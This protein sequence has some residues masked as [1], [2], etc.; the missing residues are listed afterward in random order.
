VFASSPA[1]HLAPVAVGAFMLVLAGCSQPPGPVAPPAAAAPPST[2]MTVA[3]TPKT[4]DGAQPRLASDPA[5]LADDLVADE[6][7]LRDPSTGEPGLGAGGR[8][9]PP[10]GCLS[11]HRAASRMGCCHPGTHPS[12]APRRL[13]PQCRRPSSA[14][15]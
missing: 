4:P 12:G 8:R 6:H 10:A 7:A 3:A 1:R 14:H 11:D 2:T 9:P 5:Q 13:R 15:R